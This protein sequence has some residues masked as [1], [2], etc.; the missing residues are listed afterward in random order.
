[1]LISMCQLLLEMG[2]LEEGM[3]LYEEV[4]QGKRGQLGDR[5]LNTLGSINKLATPHAAGEAGQ[6]RRSDP[7]PLYTEALEG[8]GL[9]AGMKHVAMSRSGR[10]AAPSSR[11]PMRTVI[12]LV[13]KWFAQKPHKTSSGI[14]STPRPWSI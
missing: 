7:F 14:V 1:M 13:H 10:W 8:H 9:F 5:D 6:A 11:P 4:L 3:P 12:G 2:K